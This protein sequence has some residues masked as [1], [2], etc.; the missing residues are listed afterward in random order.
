MAASWT[1]IKR[2]TARGIIVAVLAVV[3][4]DAMP[5]V[6]DELR[7]LLSPIARRMGIDQGQWSMFSPPDSANHRLRAE[8]TLRDGRVIEHRFPDLTRLSAWQRFLGHRRSEYIDNAITFGQQRREVWE[9]LAGYLARKYEFQGGG[10]G[11]I[12]I[13]VELSPIPVPAGSVWPSRSA[14]PP[15]GDQRVVYRRKFP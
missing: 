3:I 14:E 9:G 5:L 7:I 1:P 11:R 2:W 10:V 12:R 6:P 4:G 8:L 15:F 13:I